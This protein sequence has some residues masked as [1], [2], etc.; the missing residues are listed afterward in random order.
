L[1][2]AVLLARDFFAADFLMTDFRLADF[3]LADFRTLDF[4]R[5]D[6]RAAALLVP[7]FRL[8][9]FAFFFAGMR[10]SDSGVSRRRSTEMGLAA[11]REQGGPPP[12]SA[13]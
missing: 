4:R 12:P 3:R 13:P 10:I 11:G 2:E 5:L 8:A 9:G 7:R 1:R 6:L